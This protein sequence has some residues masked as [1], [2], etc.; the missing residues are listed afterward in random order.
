MRVQS[1]KLINEVKKKYSKEIR[2]A[3]FMKSDMSEIE[4]FL[5]CVKYLD[6]NYRDS[7]II[8]CSYSFGIPHHTDIATLTDGKEII[9]P[10]SRN[11]R[12]YY[13]KWTDWNGRERERR[14][15]KDVPI[16]ID[17]RQMHSLGVVKPSRR[18]LKLLGIGKI[19][20]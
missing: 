10:L 19:E 3:Q 20:K 16:E 15:N 5:V 9:V 18:P 12:N 6:D 14:L 11:S 1:S 17:V 8:T 7:Y 13:L 2:N 4:N